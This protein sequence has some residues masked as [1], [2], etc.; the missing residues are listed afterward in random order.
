LGEKQQEIL[1][2]L[3]RS[4]IRYGLPVGSATLAETMSGEH[5]ASTVRYYLGQ[6]EEGGFL[7]KAH[8]S[9]GRLPTDKA[10]RVYISAL[11]DR[12]FLSSDEE[13]QIRQALEQV[14][15]G[16]KA[17][18]SKA[19]E[20]AAEHSELMSV[21]VT[22]EPNLGVISTVKLV[23]L[24]V[25]S[26]LTVIM[27]G[28]ETAHTRV[29]HLPVEVNLLD[30]STLEQHLNAN[31]G[32]KR[33]FDIGDDLLADTFNRARV[34][35]FLLLNLRRPLTE[36]MREMRFSDEGRLQV[37]GHERIA[38]VLEDDPVRL[39]GVLSLLENE[40]KLVSLLTT[41]EGGLGVRALIGS[42]FTSEEMERFAL[43]F[44]DFGASGESRGKVG[45]LG[46]RRMDYGR[47]I[48]LVRLIGEILEEKF[49][50]HHLVIE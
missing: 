31:L 11:I 16:L 46:P 19:C 27:T 34:N 9:S 36:F 38:S 30:L 3:I 49:H 7:R 43:I 10:Y 17:L 32:G 15:L 35:Q 42:D 48:P 44:T 23:S 21:V 4:F 6:L 41:I 24:S 45:I 13:G 22:P 25:N 12:T 33:L 8:T 29:V 50:R 47:I 39:R 40:E 26:I 37:K 20:V 18:I 14:R 5:K 2:E 28:D 1:F